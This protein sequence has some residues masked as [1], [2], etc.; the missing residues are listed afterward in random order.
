MIAKDAMKYTMPAE[1]E[2]HEACW[3]AWPSHADLWGEDLPEVQREFKAFCQAIAYA[4]AGGRPETLRV[5]APN[6]QRMEDARRELAGLPV[7]V[8]PIPFGDVWL[9]D[10][11]PV[12]LFDE[13]DRL[14]AGCFE[15]NGWGEKYSL[16]SDNDV[17][18]QIAAAVGGSRVK[19]PW[20]LEGGS[21][22]VDGEG[23]CL[24]TEQ[25]LLN[26]NRNPNMSR[27][28]IENAL[29][30]SLGVTKVL[31]L[32][33]GLVN[34]H[35]DGHIDT[36][37]RFVAP[38]KVVCMAPSGP[39]DPNTAALLKI[40]QDLRGFTDARGRKLEVFT[41]PSPGLILDDTEKIMPASYVNFYL[42]NHSVIVP[43]YGAPNDD[44]AVAA[45]GK[46]FPGRRAVGLMSGY[47]LTGGGAFHCITQQQPLAR[48]RK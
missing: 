41:V 26:P 19:F 47:L 22:E 39:K 35:T 18:N 14:T 13:K 25:C 34:D 11:A 48:E 33:Q 1:W 21:I 15:F 36:L 32:G 20:V 30:E 9:R 12:F 46:L 40:E 10:T 29:R 31:W 43:I 17:S 38:G 45:I 44:A 8:H 2:A 27:S 28:Q 5:L 16:P 23:T 42:S 4:P 37:A 24:T 7:E 3:V 6:P